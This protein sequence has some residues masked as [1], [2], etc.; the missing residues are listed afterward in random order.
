[1]TGTTEVTTITP[2]VT[3]AHMLA[4]IWSTGTANGFNTGG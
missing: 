1:L 3:G 2:P 4:F